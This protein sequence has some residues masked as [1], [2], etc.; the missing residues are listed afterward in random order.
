M[1][2]AVTEL[3]PI[4]RRAGYDVEYHR[5]E[6]DGTLTTSLWTRL[7]RSCDRQSFVRI[8][9][10]Q[11]VLSPEE[12]AEASAL[13]DPQRRSEALTSA[14]AATAA[15]TAATALHSS[16]EHRVAVYGAQ[17]YP[18]HTGYGREPNFLSLRSLIQCREW[19]DEYTWGAVAS[20]MR[21]FVDGYY[22]AQSGTCFTVLM[23]LQ[24]PI[25]MSW[26]D[27]WYVAVPHMVTLVC[28]FVLSYYPTA[29]EDWW[30]TRVLGLPGLD[31][32]QATVERLAPLVEER[33]GCRL[34]FRAEP[35]GC[36]GGTAA[37]VC[38]VP[39]G[40]NDSG[41]AEPPALLV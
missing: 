21:P 9:P 41:G 10:F 24:I 25:A 36:L 1:E 35:E 11:G 17:A 39:R 26:V 2:A 22:Q 15:T 14:A 28:F 32:V 12:A 3:A 7:L 29:V 18:G 30:M 34:L 23:L 40:N 19:L 8:V 33:S 13:W 38:F 37:Y 4:F 20:E 31:E 27:T 6:T 16:G 5:G